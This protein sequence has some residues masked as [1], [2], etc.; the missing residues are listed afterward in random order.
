M[1]QLVIEDAAGHL[2][3]YR[4]AMAQLYL[5]LTLEWVDCGLLVSGCRMMWCLEAWCCHQAH[6]Q[7]HKRHAPRTWDSD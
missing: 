5:W 6:R 7:W 3:L 1:L 4:V 2:L